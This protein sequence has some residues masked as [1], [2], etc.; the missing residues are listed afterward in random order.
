VKVIITSE[1]DHSTES[2]T[3]AIEHLSGG[4]FP[5]GGIR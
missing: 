5:Y 1:S 2:N 3:D 4:I